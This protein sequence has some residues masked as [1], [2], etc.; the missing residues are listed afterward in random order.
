LL[1]RPAVAALDVTLELVPPTALLPLELLPPFAAFPPMALLPTLLPPRLVASVEELPPLALLLLDAAMVP[2]DAGL[3]APFPPLP[4]AALFLAPPDADVAA[5]FAPPAVVGVVCFGSPLHA[6]NVSIEVM[7]TT[8]PGQKRIGLLLKVR[9]DGRKSQIMT[10]SVS[11]A[12]IRVC[13]DNHS[14]AFVG[15]SRRDDDR[16]GAAHMEPPPG[17]WLRVR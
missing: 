13:G 7:V 3:L 5:E 4:P 2:P 12:R 9:L 14:G 6:P 17:Q 16:S 1:D 8:Q 10:D 15:F 11:N